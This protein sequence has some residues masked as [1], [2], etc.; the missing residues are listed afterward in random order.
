[1]AGQTQRASLVPERMNLAAEW[2]N[3][4]HD[5]LEL[6]VDHRKGD[7]Q[8]LC[9][10]RSG[11]EQVGEVQDAGGKFLVGWLGSFAD[12]ETPLL[13]AE[14]ARAHRLYAKARS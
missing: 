3:P 10:T 1:M 11:S 14:R 6:W 4:D 12:R 8:I 9:N 5:R 13:N 2:D 7:G